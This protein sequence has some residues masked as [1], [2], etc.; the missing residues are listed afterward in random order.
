MQTR[1]ELLNHLPSRVRV[2]CILPTM[3]F[4]SCLASRKELQGVTDKVGSWENRQMG[5]GGGEDRQGRGG[6]RVGKWAGVR[7]EHRSGQRTNGGARKVLASRTRAQQP[8]R[9]PGI[10]HEGAVSRMRAWWAQW[11]GQGCGEG[12][13]SSTDEG[14]ARGTLAPWMRRAAWTVG[15]AW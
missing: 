14:A 9:G 10:T 5:V 6:G 1:F 15:C 3:L 7:W 2:W 8:G 13:V 12:G 4:F 11:H